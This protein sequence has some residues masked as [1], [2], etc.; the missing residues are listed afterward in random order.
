MKAIM[1]MF[2]SLN[3]RMLSCYGCQDVETPNFDRLARRAVTFDQCYIG[4]MPCMPARRELHTGRYNFFHRSWGPLEPFDDSMPE[5]L[6]RNGVHTHLVS[7]HQHYWEDGGATYHTRYST[8]EANRGQEGDPWIGMVKDPDTLPNDQQTRMMR[9][10]MTA[11][12]MPD[13]KKNDVVNRSAMKTEEDMPQA[14]TFKNGLEFI[15]RNHGEDKWFLQI[16][17]FDP[18]EPFFASERFKA[19]YPDPDGY[20]GPDFDWPSYQKVKEPRE[21][22]EHCVNRYKALVSMCDHYLG[23]VLDA[24]DKYDLW[25]D[26]MLVVNTDHGFLLGEHEWWGK[27][28]MPHYN[29]IA[30]IPFFMWN[31]QV[32]K[33]GERRRSLV[34]TI[35][36]APTLLTWFGLEP[37]KDMTGH[38]LTR[39]LED[40]TPVREFALFGTHGEFVNMTDGRYVYMRRPDTGVCQY[41]YT[42]MPTHMRTRFSAEELKG[43]ALAEPFSF[44][45]EVP[46]LKIPCG[47]TMR[48]NLEAFD[49]VLY[50]L[51]TDPG[52]QRPV[53]DLEK[54]LEFINRLRLLM[55]ENDAPDEAYEAMGFSKEEPYTLEQLNAEKEKAAHPVL[56]GFEEYAVTKDAYIKLKSLFRLMP[57]E[58][59]EQMEAGLK[60]MLRTTGAKEICSGTVLAFV[61]NLSIEEGQKNMLLGMIG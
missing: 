11:M 16:E 52:Q 57:K 54:E 8:W 46:L 49:T 1:V 59:R 33:E 4:S 51:E 48:I 13:M 9:K 19:M 44:T 42:L 40:D 55:V 35:D 58:Q 23:Q 24:M 7:D 12:G 41:E 25:K 18:H 36:L 17:T 29:E 60:Q 20:D 31:P 43:L 22:R 27:S 53:S 21:Q 38:D 39:V 28:A 30:H 45:K 26:T 6:K 61:E 34:Q 37:T 15:E 47:A 5:I 10:A 56:A 32:G 2:D 3:R 50:D 14:R